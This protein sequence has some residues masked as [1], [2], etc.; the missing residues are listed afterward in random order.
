MGKASSGWRRS[1]WPRFSPGSPAL[2][3]CR[4]VRISLTRRPRGERPPD[5]EPTLEFVT[6][7]HRLAARDPAIHALVVAVR[8]LARLPDALDAPDL[9]ERVKAEMAAVP[10][11]AELTTLGA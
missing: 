9:V 11:R 4:R 6:A 1:T 3:R 8:Q 5:L 2:G 10:P 7:L